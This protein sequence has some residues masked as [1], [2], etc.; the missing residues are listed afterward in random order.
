M[1]RY[2][3]IG[4]H[5]NLSEAQ[6][7]QLHGNLNAGRNLSSTNM[8]R[9]MQGMRNRSLGNIRRRASN[10]SGVRQLR[11]GNLGGSWFA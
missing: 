7:T 9:N 2:S 1:G 8:I 11:P 3:F 5:Q 6:V 10:L 4:S